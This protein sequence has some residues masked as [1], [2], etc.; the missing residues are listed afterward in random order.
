M[1]T[2]SSL[3]SQ[4]LSNTGTRLWSS[5]PLYRGKTRLRYCARR[6]GTKPKRGYAVNLGIT[7]KAVANP[8]TNSTRGGY[9]IL[10]Y[11]CPPFLRYLPADDKER[12]DVS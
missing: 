11:E 12:N 9:L 4:S 2:F 6:Y 3:S 5:L 10:E 7:T 1:I 8:T